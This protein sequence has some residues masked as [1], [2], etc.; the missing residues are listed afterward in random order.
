MTTPLSVHDLWVDLAGHHVLRG[1]SL[2]VAPGEVVALLGANGS[3]K[4]TVVRAAVGLLS[5]RSGHVEVFGTPSTRFTDRARLGYV[6]QRSTP[7]TGVPATV[8][9]IVMSGRLSRRRFF[10]PPSR[11]DRK[12]VKRAIGDMGLGRERNKRV[13]E[14]SGGQQQ[15]TLIAR[16]LAARPDLLIMDEP[17]AGVDYDHTVALTNVIRDFTADGGSVLLVEHELGPLRP[18]IDRV[19]VLDAGRVEFAGKPS[20]LPLDEHG[21]IHVHAH[22]HTA[23]PETLQP[24]PAEGVL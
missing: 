15:R 2:T 21:H 22:P 5:P 23:E 4:S 16:A 17:T 8:R 24:V 3:G 13:T 14:L 12:A 9:E 20:D 10:G 19:I 6:P 18:V 1:V 7:P 11:A